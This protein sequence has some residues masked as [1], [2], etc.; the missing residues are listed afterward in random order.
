[1]P[2]IPRDVEVNPP[3]PLQDHVPS[4][5]PFGCGPRFTVDPDGTVA[6]AVCCQAAPFI[7]R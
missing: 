2:K 1:M 3:G 5:A 7:C 6:V 4:H